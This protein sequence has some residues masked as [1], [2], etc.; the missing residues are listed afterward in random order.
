MVS[1]VGKERE[2][3]FFLFHMHKSATEEQK[4]QGMNADLS[5]ELRGNFSSVSANKPQ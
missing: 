2:Q 5:W 3:K 4:S 1:R